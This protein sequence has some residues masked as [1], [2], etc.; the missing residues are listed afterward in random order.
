MRGARP[1]PLVVAAPSGAGKTS[2]ARAL[3][4][5]RSDLVFSVSVTTRERRP[6]ETDG[7]DYTFVDDDE[8]DALIEAGELVEWA[9]VHDARYGTTRRAIQSALDDGRVVVLDIDIQGAKAIRERFEEAVLVFVLPPSGDE[10]AR[11]LAGRGSEAEAERRRRLRNARDELPSAPGFDYV[12][13][14]DDFDA[15]VAALGAIVDAELRRVPRQA[16]LEEALRRIDTQIAG[17]LEED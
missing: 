15:G 3:L 11:R 6:H 12:V 7:V 16:A 14:N 4:E 1:F 9:V 17:I 5:A 13:V 10:L 8:F 2:L